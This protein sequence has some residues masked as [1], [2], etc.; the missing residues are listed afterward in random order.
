[1]TADSGLS[2]SQ[3]QIWIGQT[4]HPDSP[5]YNMAFA[6]V[7]EGE[8]DT[9]AFA[10]AWHRV[11]D[12][13]DALRTSVN[14]RTGLVRVRD[15]GGCATRFLDFS[16]RADTEQ[17]FRAWAL[18]RCVRPLP[19]GGELVDSVIVKLSAGR[20]GWYLNQHHIVTDASSTVQL[21]RQVAAEYAEAKQGQRPRSSDAGTLEPYYPTVRGLT[22]FPNPRAREAA[23]SHWAS[24]RQHGDRI[25]QFYG[26][27]STTG[28]TRSERLTL[29]L[30]EATTRRLEAA[31]TEEGFL[32]FTADISMFAVF[33]TLLT[34]W[35]HRITGATQ[36]GFDAP[37]HN[38]PTPSAKRSLGLFIEMFPFAVAVEPGESFRSL[39][40]K[41]LAETQQFLRFALPGTSS[42]PGARPGNVVL[43]FFSGRFGGFAGLPVVSEWVH[44]GHADSVH[45]LRLQIHDYD[46]LDSYTLHFDCNEE[47]FPA[48]LR[49]RA[50]DHFS[51]LLH[52]FLHDPDTPIGSVDILTE[53]ERAAVIVDFNDTAGPAPPEQP[54]TV[55]FD[56]QAIASADRIALREGRREV[57]F[58]EL[59]RRA[60]IAATRLVQIGVLPGEPVAVCMKRSIDVVVAVLAV[61]KARGAYV[62]IDPGYPAAR[63]RL[64]LDDC[65]AK[66]VLASDATAPAFAGCERRLL[67]ID[68]LLDRTPPA[69]VAPT[70]LD[71]ARLHDL[72]YII[73]TSGSTGRPK[74][75]AVEHLGLAEY[76]E[77]AARQYVR[78][79]RLTFPLF[80]SLSFDL[81]ITSLFLPLISGGTLVIYE[82]TDGPV[83]AAL[84]DVV[85]ENR[86]DFIKLT[87]SHLSLL[88]RMKPTSSRIR[89]MVVGGEDLKTSLAAAVT[90][91]FDEPVEIYNEYGPTE[92]VVGC[93]MH[94]Y[95]PAIDTG[96]SV[97]IG[98]PADHVRVYVLNDALVPVPEGVPGELCASR[99][100]LARGY[101]RQQA[102]TER[103]F[104]SDPF[105][106]T[107]RLYRTGDLVRFVR[108]GTLEYLGRIDSQ[109]K[110][111]GFRAE[112]GEIEAALLTHEAIR[113]CVVTFGRAASPRILDTTY[114]ERCGIPSNA[115]DVVLDAQGVCSV[116]LSFESVEVRAR[117]YFGTMADLAAIFRESA[118]ERSAPYDCMML[119]SGGKDSTYALC[120]LV[121]MGLSVYAFSFDNGY[122]SEQAK[123]NVRRVVTALGVDHEFATT[124]A[125]NAIFRDS[126]MRFSNVCNGCF[127]TIYTLG[128]N[129]ARD[130]GIPIIVT[131][132]SRGQLFETRLTPNLF[133]DGWRSAAE[134]DAAVLAA[135]RAYHRM[136]DQVSR[137]LNVSI[138]DDDAVFEQIRFVD[139]YRYC[140]AG[141]DEILSYLRTA[142]PWL[143]P[144]DTGRSTNCLINDVGIYIHQKERGHHNYA[145]PY[146]WDVRLGLKTRGEAMA[147][148]RDEIDTSRV[149]RILAEI[150]YDE[151]R[152]SDVSPPDT[153]A[154][155]FVSSREIPDLELRRHLAATLPRPLIPQ[156][157]TRVDAMPLTPNG[158]V[159]RDRLVALDAAAPQGAGDD[160]VLEGAAQQRIAMIWQEV[161][162]IGAVGAETS[163]FE[164]GGTS[165]AAMEVMLRICDEF[166][167]DLPLQT[168]FQRQTIAQLARA[169]EDVIEQEIAGLSDDDAEKLAADPHARP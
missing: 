154:A 168:L 14:Q 76:L 143:R 63:I 19:L 48:P 96:P 81:T 155:Y 133:R 18:E 135:R 145:L 99:A 9:T 121:D 40:R 32:S 115:P 116:C 91:R 25:A 105:Q 130:L 166:E 134:V 127:K 119:L 62:P 153:L 118:A 82:E 112:P 126:L 74:G 148:L 98:R 66:C 5:L 1:M 86:A 159:D 165:L 27:R 147:E 107:D 158:K 109:L 43:N 35:L 49:G 93:V 45:A 31:G 71:G 114:C 83:D 92:A 73:Y 111:S 132:L 151:D 100:G 28:S 38:R 20:Y 11:V 67:R 94:R 56:R 46:G 139:F 51:A 26:R 152:V 157:F 50:V 30:D 33:A 123:E 129:R 97:P 69:G 120:R 110:I 70:L 149:R 104:V 90:A 44:S 87:P 89:R 88:A 55:L 106:P 124:P 65:G 4:L 84:L 2:T 77:W 64:L 108:P 103:A 3:T 72:A 142:V 78:G 136:D 164:R 37:A 58:A 6:F 102:A 75:V 42:S 169:V 95:D 140:D 156:R 8:I 137:S 79:D 141:L 167:V 163:F 60:D 138:F 22:S 36:L 122:I 80:T 47:V 52:A 117:A 15:A 101:H 12:R 41:C 160:A 161:L 23:A 85:D 59:R 7:L 53:E 34:A 39:G 113:E 125:M 24:R 54:V 16:G 68:E 10:A 131:G 13:S 150:G 29:R 61:L 146:S 162:H 57:T 144:S 21:F 17:E 128:M